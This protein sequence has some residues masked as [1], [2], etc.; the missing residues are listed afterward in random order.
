MIILNS[1]GAARNLQ[2]GRPCRRR[3]STGSRVRRSCCCRIGLRFT[4]MVLRWRQVG[5]LSFPMNVNKS[6]LV[7]A[8]AW[9]A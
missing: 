9:W 7:Y 8:C 3:R 6:I 5:L 4:D 1:L 2:K